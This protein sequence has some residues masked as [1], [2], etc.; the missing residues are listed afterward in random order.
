MLPVLDYSCRIWLHSETFNIWQI[1][2]HCGC[3][4]FFF[5]KRLNWHTDCD[6]TGQLTTD[7]DDFQGSVPSQVK[8]KLSTRFHGLNHE[9]PPGSLMSHTRN[10]GSWSGAA[11]KGITVCFH[12]VV[13]SQLKPFEAQLGG[14]DNSAHALW[15]FWG[16][17]KKCLFTAK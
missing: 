17:N 16:L 14:T 7:R 13:S 5:P 10:Y 1:R 2:H 11:L 9:R 12:W 3:W 8:S 15:G 6:V 4:L